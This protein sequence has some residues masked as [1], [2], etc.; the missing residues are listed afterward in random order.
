MYFGTTQEY[1]DI[2]IGKTVNAIPSGVKR[3]LN[4]V[5][6]ALGH[7]TQTQTHTNT[8]AD[9]NANMDYCDVLITVWQAG[10]SCRV[11]RK[12][13]QVQDTVMTL[14]KG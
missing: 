11:P 1:Y 10:R 8:H 14:L 2:S 6:L 4:S 9:S 3:E 12:A 13:F 7:D 5:C